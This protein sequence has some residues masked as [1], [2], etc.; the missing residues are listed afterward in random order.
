MTKRARAGAWTFRTIPLRP[1]LMVALAACAA[2]GAAC[3]GHT[4]GLER[5]QKYRDRIAAEPGLV[6]LY[7]FEGVADSQSPVPDLVGDD[8]LTFVPYAAKDAEPVDDLAII[9]GRWPGK[10]AVSLDQGWYEGPPFDATAEGFTIECWFRERGPG[11]LQPRGPNGTLLS[12]SSGYYDGWRITFS[13]KSHTVDFALG[14]PKP[15]YSISARCVNPIARG[16]WIHLAATWDGSLTRIFLNGVARGEQ[17]F[18]GPYTPAH[19]MPK[20]KVGFAGYGVGSFKFDVDMVAL[21]ERALTRDEIASHANPEGEFETELIAHLLRGDEL[22]AGGAADRFERARE[23]YARIIA[24]EDDGLFEPLANY[25]LMARLRIAGS[26]RAQ[27]DLDRARADYRSIASDDSVELHWRMQAWFALAQTHVTQRAYSAAR[28]EYESILALVTGRHEHYRVEAMQRLADIETL[29]DGAP[30]VSGRQRRLDR[31]SHPA[32]TLYVAT[33]GDDANPGTEAAPLGTLERARD[34]VRELKAQGPLP[35]GGVAV[36]LRGG[37]YRLALSFRLSA[38]DSG[39]EQAPVV[40]Q[41]SPGEEVRLTGGVAVA[42]FEP[43]TDAPSL[44]R[45]PEEARGHVLVAD[46]KAQGIT[47]YGEITPR[48]YGRPITPAHMELFYD[49]APMELARWPNK[50]PRM[51][52]GFVTIH[53]LLLTNKTV[54]RGDDVEKDLHFVYEGERP[55]RWVNEPDVWL[56][57]YWAVEYAAQYQKVKSIDTQRHVIEI[58]PPAPSYCLRKGRPWRALNLLPELDSPGEYYLDRE[59][60]RLYFW[61]PDEGKGLAVVSLL[62][63]PL[64]VLDGCSHVVL[65]GL[66]LEAGRADGVVRQGGEGNRVA[67]CIIRNLG[68]TGVIVK[69]GQGHGVLGCDVYEVGDSGIHMSGGDRE[70][71]TPA[72]HFAENNHLHRF[73]RWDRAGYRSGMYMS[74]VGCRASHNLIHDCPHHAVHMRQNDHVLEYNEL[75]DICY[76]AAEMGCYYIWGGLDSFSWRGNVVRYNSFHHL[77]GSN[78]FP[79]IRTGGPAM[80]IDALNGAICVFGNVFHQ[81]A[82]TAVFNGGGRDNIVENNIFTHCGTSVVLGDR[83]AL[84]PN[85]DW[86]GERKTD[87][88]DTLRRLPY[89]EPP[90]SLRYPQLVGILDDEPGLPKNNVI[91]RNINV[92]QFMRRHGAARD[93]AL[94]TIAD[95]WDGDDP[96]F[97]DLNGLD[98]RISDD[99]PVFGRIGFEQIPVERIGLYQDELRAT[100]PMAHNVGERWVRDAAWE[101]RENVPTCTARKRTSTIRVDG[102]LGPEEWDGLDLDKAV[103]LERDPKNREGANPKSWA[104]V[105]YDAEALYIGILNEVVPDKPLAVGTQWG[106]HD[107]VEVAIEGQMGDLCKGWW[108]LENEHGPIF[109]LCGNTVGDFECLR[110]GGLPAGPAAA[111]TEATTY[112]ANVLDDAH[113]SAE[114]RIPLQAVC[115]NPEELDRRPFNIG[116][117]KTAGPARVSDW[118]PGKGPAG[119]VVW[120]GTGNRNWEVWNAGKLDFTP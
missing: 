100:W 55:E 50:S 4:S 104:W 105:C 61:P 79:H 2:V 28:P 43:V 21:Y 120:V 82:A 116:V 34:A 115:I 72:G 119:W 35:D 24:I 32:V 33:D 3:C 51:S 6:R 7:T 95:N 11:T 69:G 54:F 29:A 36:Y 62:A 88:A 73:S 52:E 89:Q 77:P 5:W 94:N 97:V 27:G 87:M 84:Y 103:V 45:L 99:S 39:T 92:G 22:V 40:Y 96:G 117:R 15:D 10:P 86:P 13:D 118:Q 42:G 30:Y 37:S 66:T 46:L 112:G 59:A 102:R 74:G 26:F 60:G 98:F 17:A 53:D 85:W 101:R 78:P 106:L 38:E 47:D 80:H 41:A 93:D 109:M 75:H 64:V 110:V 8:A 58:E 1:W 63:E 90:W 83:Q 91:A 48:G 76:E 9:P 19:V 44:A 14:R 111:L 113:W 16:E 12:V 68:N 108:V 31:I 67:G 25:K 65:R 49:G 81:I 71:L 107:G 70:T 18:A 57:G 20:F 56:Y 23:E 114:W